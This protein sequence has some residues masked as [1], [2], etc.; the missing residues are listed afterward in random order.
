MS[1]S[2]RRFWLLKTEPREWSWADQ[3]SNGGVS[4]WDGVKNRQAQNNMKAMKTGDLCFFYHSGPKERRVVGVVAVAKE[5]YCCGEDEWAVDV[6]GVGAMGR[7]VELK[8]IKE[9]GLKDFALIKQPRLSVVP[10]PDK[11]WERICE[12]GGGYEG[13]SGEDAAGA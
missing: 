5:W 4:K 6:R 8:E 12:M 11:I 13:K 10:V 1:S 3:A 2:G 9:E 7:P